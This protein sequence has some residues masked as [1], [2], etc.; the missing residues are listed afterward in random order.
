M[1]AIKDIITNP[2]NPNFNIKINPDDKLGVTDTLLIEYV[3]GY[4]EDQYGK[5]RGNLPA[6]DKKGIMHY[7]NKYK[8]KPKGFLANTIKR[9]NTSI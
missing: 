1:L 3:A 5:V 9:N 4:F 2:E 8:N 7:I 6:A